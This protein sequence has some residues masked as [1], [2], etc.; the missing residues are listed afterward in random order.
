MDDWISQLGPFF[1]QFSY[2]AVFLILL[3][4]GIGLPV[5]EEATFLVAGYFV[6]KMGL[7]P[8]LMISVALAGIVLGDSITFFLGRGLGAA[9]LTR[10]PFKKLISEQGLAR[11]QAFFRKHGPKAIFIA[12]CMAGVRAPTFFLSGSMGLSYFRFLF[13]DFAR[14]LVTCPLSIFLGYKFGPQAEE[15]ISRYQ[16]WFFG[17]LGGLALAFLIH[18]LVRHRRKKRRMKDEG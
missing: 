11:A 8:G 5:P 9:L 3:L 13:W 2:L 17:L 14:S 15:Y 12:G 7:S 6:A 10:W 1:D 16:F 4:C 18:G